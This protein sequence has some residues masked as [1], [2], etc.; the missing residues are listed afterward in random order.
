MNIILALLAI[1]GW[2]YDGFTSD[3]PKP[4]TIHDKDEFPELPVAPLHKWPE[5]APVEAPRV[6]FP[7]TEAVLPPRS[8][9]TFPVTVEAPPAT[10][11]SLTDASGQAWQHTD[12]DWLRRWVEQRNN[13][14]NAT[15]AKG[16]FGPSAPAGY[17]CPSGRCYRTR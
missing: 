12:P 7:K 11:W 14:F 2:G 10:I 16:L 1:A 17:S 4:Y 15:A 13:S 5:L 3:P 8:Q 9:P 6:S